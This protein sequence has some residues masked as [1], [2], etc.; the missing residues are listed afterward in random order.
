MT[1]KKIIAIGGGENGRVKSDGT[2]H[3]YEL[4]NQ[5]IEIIRLTKKEHPNF[6]FLAHTFAFSEEIQ[7]DYYQTM[8][9]TTYIKIQ[10]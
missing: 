8:K 4:E 9:N 3:P 6:L 1:N 10:K 5:D 7:E 2:R